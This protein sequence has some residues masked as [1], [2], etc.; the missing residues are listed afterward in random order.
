M[1]SISGA[2]EALVTSEFGGA[3]CWHRWI[4]LLSAERVFFAIWTFRVKV[5]NSPAF[6]PSEEF[7]VRRVQELSTERSPVLI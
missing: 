5:N 6:D 3:G 4:D 1:T 7:Y 2:F